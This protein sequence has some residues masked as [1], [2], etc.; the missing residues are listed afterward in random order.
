MSGARPC[1]FCG[2]PAEVMGT[3]PVEIDCSNADCPISVYVCEDTI[4]EALR[5]WNRRSTEDAL[6]DALREIAES[7]CSN[8]AGSGPARAQSQ[9]AHRIARAA[10]AR[11]AARE[12]GKR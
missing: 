3:G 10:L 12:E 9:D 4:P 7:T 8:P 2:G 11:L 6:A 1:P 5:V